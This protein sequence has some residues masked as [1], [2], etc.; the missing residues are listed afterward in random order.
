MKEFFAA[1][2]EDEPLTF[3]AVVLAGD[4]D[5]VVYDQDRMAGDYE[6]HEKLGCCLQK[7]W[8]WLMAERKKQRM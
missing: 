4:A 6:G 7:W 8:W 1:G 5:A 2:G 3:T